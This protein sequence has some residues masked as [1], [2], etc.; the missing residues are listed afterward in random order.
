[1]EGFPISES[2]RNA[3]HRANSL[4]NH[5]HPSGQAMRHRSPSA[6]PQGREH[7]RTD[8]DGSLGP[9]AYAPYG[10]SP[11]GEALEDARRQRDYERHYPSDRHDPMRSSMYELP[12]R[13][14][15]ARPRYQSNA[16]YVDASRGHHSSDEDY[17]RSAGG[18][19]R[20]GYDGQKYYR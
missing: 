20:N 17:Y 10:S 2:A 5:H 1:M 4:L 9:S 13:E 11:S 14:R 7:R 16:G 18:R 19:P 3:R 6:N 15:E 8:G 12:T